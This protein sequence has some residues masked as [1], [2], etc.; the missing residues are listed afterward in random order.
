MRALRFENTLLLGIV[1]FFIIGVIILIVP[2]PAT[3]QQAFK[4][5]CAAQN[6]IVYHTREG[7]LCM[8]QDSV[9]VIG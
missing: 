2:G 9:I 6:G 8:K 1:I 7:T 3:K 4:S 5:K